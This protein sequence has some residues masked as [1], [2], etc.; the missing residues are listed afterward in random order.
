MDV[1]KELFNS[2]N[3]QDITK[4]REIIDLGADVNFID[5]LGETPLMNASKHNC[6][7]CMKLLLDSGAIQTI[8]QLSKWNY[9][10]LINAVRNNCYKCVELLL[11]SGADPNVFVRGE[12]SPLIYAA[13][14]GSFDIVKLLVNAGAN[15]NYSNRRG[16]TALMMASY[17]CK[18]FSEQIIDYLVT[19]GANV[20][21]RNN[22][23]ETALIFACLQS[24]LRNVEALI[25]HGA[26][27]N[28]LDHDRRSP[29]VVT[30]QKSDQNDDSD[31]IAQ[32][33]IEAGADLSVVDSNGNTTLILA[34]DNGYQGAVY[35]IIR[36]AP[37]LI[38]IANRDG[39]TALQIALEKRHYNIINKLLANGAIYDRRYFYRQV[40]LL[41]KLNNGKS[42]IY[43]LY[44][45]SKHDE[46][47]INTLIDFLGRKE[48]AKLF[49]IEATENNDLEALQLLKGIS[50]IKF[51]RIG[52]TKWGSLL[53]IAS[54]HSKELCEYILDIVMDELSSQFEGDPDLHD[55]F[56]LALFKYFISLDENKRIAIQ[57]AYN[58]CNIPTFEYL[59]GIMNFFNR[60]KQNYIISNF[61][62]REYP[63]EKLSTRYA[64]FISYLA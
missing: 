41:V 1:N 26:N 61:L 43:A 16:D 37:E 17:S 14:M 51:S 45:L 47:R 8:N 38:N 32:I 60:S 10:A 5:R 40:A 46:E 59:Y 36:K 19:S 3:Y 35:S 6:F 29:L 55:K 63:C 57:I 42:L 31:K 39:E 33:L 20:N 22:D 48:Y 28:L 2:K 50:D 18:K 62:I 25:K 64:E 56:N 52:T 49:A 58:D 34:S 24:C 13:T 15:I 12:F 44:L 9:T 4:L 7:D 23:G 30:L 11:Q 27:P 21:S 54:H 53:N